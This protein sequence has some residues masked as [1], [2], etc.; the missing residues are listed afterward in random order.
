MPTL[1]PYIAWRCWHA[2]HRAGDDDLAP[3][4]L[5]LACAP[6]I[7]APCLQLLLP[8]PLLPAGAGRAEGV[9][10]VPTAVL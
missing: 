5:A 8:S 7:L 1:P 10:A 4:S 3:G 2:V 6:L 9:D